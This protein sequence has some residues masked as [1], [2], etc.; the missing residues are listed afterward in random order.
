MI[1]KIK[2]EALQF[3]N[4]N[5]D[6]N[7]YLKSLNKITH[8]SKGNINF[9]IVSNDNDNDNDNGNDN[10]N[11]NGN[12][13]DNDNGNGNDNGN[14]NENEKIHKNLDR[15]YKFANGFG[16]TF[17]IYLL[18]SPFKKSFK[19]NLKSPLNQFN[20]NT[21]F[22]YL[23]SSNTKMICIVR[24]EEYLKVI[25]HEIIHHISLIHRSFKVENINRLKK[26]FKILNVNID[27]NE[28]II[29]FWATIMYLKQLSIDTNKD[30]YELFK[31]ELNYSLYKSYQINK[32]QKFNNGYW[33]DGETNL[34]CYVVFKTIIMYNIDIF[35]NI[36]TFPYD[37]TII[38][39]FLIKYSN[40][41]LA[42]AR[43]N[44]KRKIMSLCFMV[45]SDS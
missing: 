45:N 35:M 22:T 20:T 38:T 25:Y 33:K 18:L 3:L 5:E 10:D 44:S 39:D 21:G 2:E 17:N 24:K 29:E 12:D 8:I 4:Y 16:Y 6:F 9:F 32:L 1:N 14:D 23:T 15:I 40:L 11:D 41:P 13:N 26:H 19:N 36:Y 37:D 43:N 7:N 28:A 42:N 34:Y 30:F 27:P 31:E